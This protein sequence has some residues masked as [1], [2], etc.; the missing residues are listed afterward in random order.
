MAAQATRV[1]SDVAHYAWMVFA[2]LGAVFI[3]LGIWPG[4]FESHGQTR[5]YFLSFLLI[6]ILWVLLA[7]AARI[8]GG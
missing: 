5:Q 1:V 7:A 8:T 2:G 4:L 3:L 6:N